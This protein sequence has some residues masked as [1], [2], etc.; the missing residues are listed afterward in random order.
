MEHE[1]TLDDLVQTALGRPVATRYPDQGQLERALR[2]LP[3][4]ALELIALLGPSWPPPDP[5]RTVDE[6][7]VDKTPPAPPPADDTEG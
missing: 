3:P 2:A 4:T 1:V 5:P 7:A 6:P